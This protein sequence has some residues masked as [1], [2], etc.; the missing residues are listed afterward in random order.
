VK[1]IRPSA[2]TDEILT[3]VGARL[4]RYRLQQD[5]TV[6]EVAASAGVGE[7]TLVRAEA[8]EN[9]TLKTVVKVLRALGRV[10][11][12][13]AFLPP[14]LVSPIQLAATSGRERQR[15]S[16]SG[17]PSPRTPEKGAGRG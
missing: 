17:A 5:R 4:Q 10:E 8:G 2:T 13:D 6:E 7:R 16:G 3:E 14:P 11:A 12:L 1:R 15:A 9:T